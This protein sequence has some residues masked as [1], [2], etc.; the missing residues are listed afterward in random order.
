MNDYDKNNYCLMS[1]KSSFKTTINQPLH[2]YVTILKRQ[3]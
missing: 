3:F 1:K 2:I